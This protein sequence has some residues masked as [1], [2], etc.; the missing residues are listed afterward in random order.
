MNGNLPGFIMS[1]ASV[2][3][4]ADPTLGG[5]YTVREAAR[6]LQIESTPRIRG[7]L[8]GYAHRAGPIIKRQYAPVGGIHEVGFLDLMEIRFVEHFRKQGIS[9]QSLRVAAKNARREL[10]QEHPFATSNVKFM[11]DR[12]EVFLHTAKLTGDKFL[13]NL[14]TNQIEIYEAFE[15]LL[16]EGVDFDPQTGI[17][18][19]WCPHP[20]ECPNVI[21]DPRIAFGHP[22][23]AP[24]YV[25]TKA[26]F[27]LWMA[28]NGNIKAVAEWFHV[29]EAAVTEA[30]KFEVRLAA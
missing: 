25:P 9:L 1:V 20:A 29:E 21:V 6:L 8:S 12:K 7:W 11:T 14:M 30:I 23:I 24:R 4:A 22:V 28:E 2:Q 19:R 10:Q 3:T 27:G 13:L 15:Q 17:A 5:F 16:A 18:N 26:L